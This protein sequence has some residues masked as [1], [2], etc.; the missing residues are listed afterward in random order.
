MKEGKQ[1]QGKVGKLRKNERRK[2]MEGKSN[3]MNEEEEI[4]KERW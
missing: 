3:K 2:A 1:W 4:K